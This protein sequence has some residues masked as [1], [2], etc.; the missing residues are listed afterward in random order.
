MKWKNN[1]NLTAL[2]L[3]ILSISCLGYIRPILGINA[4]WTLE[5]IQWLQF[6]LIILISTKYFP[7]P[8]LSMILVFYIFS[9]AILF[10]TTPWI[11]DD[12]YRY[13]WDGRLVSEGINPYLLAPNDSFWINVNSLWR[14]HINFPEITTI[15][16]PLTQIYFALIYIFFGESIFGLRVG[17]LVFEILTALL[18]Y[19]IIIRK[20]LTLKPLALFLFFPTLLK[21]NIN[22]LHFDLI[23]SFFILLFYYLFEQPTLSFKKN[24]LAWSSLAFAILIKLFPLLLIPTAFFHKKNKWYGILLLTL[25]IGLSYYPFLDADLHV[26]KG[27]GAFAKDFHADV[28]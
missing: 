16:P 5:I 11:E 7:T 18:V 1:L 12:Y 26:F 13:L 28:A 24:M 17:C 21:E 2:A 20:K 14:Q 8:S 27:S 10:N 15:Y 19:K 25:I 23:A 22:S 3:L 9:R 6:A 4:F